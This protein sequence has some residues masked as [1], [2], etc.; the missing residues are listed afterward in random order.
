A[1]AILLGGLIEL[2]L[3]RP[4]FA[5]ARLLQGAVAAVVGRLSCSPFVAVGFRELIAR[6][7]FVVLFQMVKRRGLIDGERSDV[8]ILGGSGLV[9][10]DGR[11]VVAALESR[12]GLRRRVAVASKQPAGQDQQGHTN[13]QDNR[14]ALHRGMLLSSQVPSVYAT[15]SLRDRQRA[16]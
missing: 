2:F 9:L 16:R 14:R 11:G 6:F 7:C 5:F 1:G 12:A 3:V 8:G 10:A 13:R 15:S 4:A